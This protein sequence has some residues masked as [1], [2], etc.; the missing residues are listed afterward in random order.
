MN[1]HDAKKLASLFTES[2]VITDAGVP[3]VARGR[4]SI[5]ARYRRSFDAFSDFTA[6]PSRIFVTGDVAIVEWS[7]RGTHTGDLG[8]AKATHE[9]TGA[10]AV[11][12][13]WFA[14]DGRVE[15]LHSYCDWN[16]VLA[17]V[18]ASP[19]R[20]RPI[21][22][23]ATRPLIVT[24]GGE[25]EPQ[26]LAM[27][28]T[29]L[30]AWEKKS[31]SDFVQHLADD[32]T[33]DDLTQA[34]T[35]RGKPASK[36]LFADWIKAFPDAKTDTMNAWAIGDFVIVEGTFSGTHQGAFAG[37]PPTKKSLHVHGIDIL[38]FDDGKI[39]KGWS[40]TNG[41][42]AATQLGLVPPR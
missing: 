41:L 17:H 35:I 14:A 39:V 26:N 15:V 27:A 38:Q 3:I 22:D 12:V 24:N 28:R 21:P 7:W 1:A 5:E 25:A 37:I 18:G 13:L 30:G 19:A 8:P 2:A 23:L 9:P 40:Y 32:E 6:A 4:D 10:A 11:D 31:V 33:W 34:E 29:M 16:T 36:Q 42:E 20:V